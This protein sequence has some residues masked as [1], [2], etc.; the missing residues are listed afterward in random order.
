MER[1]VGIPVTRE[2]DIS[3]L[4]AGDA[5]SAAQS[6]PPKL[7]EFP[8]GFNTYFGMERYQV[9][10]QFFWHSPALVVCAHFLI[11]KFTSAESCFLS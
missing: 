2:G 7:Y 4:P 10:E 9:G 1:R 6:R 3:Y 8:T 11:F 5:N